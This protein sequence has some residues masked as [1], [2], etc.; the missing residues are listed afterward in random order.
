[1]TPCLRASG[2]IIMAGPTRMNIMDFSRDSGKRERERG[3]RERE[4]DKQGKL[5]RKDRGPSPVHCSIAM[6]TLTSEG[7]LT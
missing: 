1:M 3:E 4:R 5:G 2:I 7:A 6:P